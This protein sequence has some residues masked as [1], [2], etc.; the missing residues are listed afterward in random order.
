MERPNLDNYIS[1]KDF[2]EFYWLKKELIEFCKKT[3]ISTGGCKTELTKRIQHYFWTGRLVTNPKKTQ[4]SI[5][6]FDWNNE[7]LN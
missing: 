5:S 3:G 7:P 2:K 1:L 6:K 4:E